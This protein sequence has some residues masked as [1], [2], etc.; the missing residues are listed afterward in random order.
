MTTVTAS[1]VGKRK[2]QPA[3]QPYTLIREAVGAAHDPRCDVM[4]VN[5]H[6]RNNRLTA[7]LPAGGPQGSGGTAHTASAWEELMLG[8]E[9][10][11]LALERSSIEK[12]RKIRALKQDNERLRLGDSEVQGGKRPLL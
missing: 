3:P 9:E 8:L 2:V 5:D 11:I 10:G 1:R 6:P 7:K 4:D 12:D